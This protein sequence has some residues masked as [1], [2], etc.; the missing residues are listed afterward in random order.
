MCSA[1][2]TY[3]EMIADCCEMERVKESETRPQVYNILAKICPK[4]KHLIPMSNELVL[5]F[6]YLLYD[7]TLLHSHISNKC[8]FGISLRLIFDNQPVFT[9]KGC[10]GISYKLEVLRFPAVPVVGTQR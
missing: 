4:C 6:K 7:Q 9:R 10:G 5:D 2:T 8:G 1:V 3:T